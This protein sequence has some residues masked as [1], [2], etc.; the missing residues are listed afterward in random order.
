MK[1]NQIAKEDVINVA[2]SL[3]IEVSDSTI[4]LILEEYDSWENADPTSNW[5]E[6]VESMLYSLKT[7]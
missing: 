5:T 4:D 6:I 3:K 1:T 2:N 7:N